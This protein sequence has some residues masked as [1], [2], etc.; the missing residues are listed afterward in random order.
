MAKRSFT[1]LV[2]ACLTATCLHAQTDT[3]H[4]SRRFAIALYPGIS[5]VIGA[6]SAL[7]AVGGTVHL[8]GGYRLSSLDFLS[9]SLGTDYTFLPV[10][11]ERSSIVSIFVLEAGALADVAVLPWLELYAGLG[12]GYFLGFVTPTFAVQGGF[13]LDIGGGAR[14]RLLP[15]LS[16]G[17]SGGYTWRYGLHHAIHAG[18][19]VTYSLGAVIASDDGEERL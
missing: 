18:I 1:I 11:A 8:S 13:N 7:Y 6:E 17:I 19:S 16:L 12:G 10:A 3:P 9:L 14:F 4:K 2:L 15:A 5:Y